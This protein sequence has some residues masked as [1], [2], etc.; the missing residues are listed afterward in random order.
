M[1][2]DVG[3]RHTREVGA[4]AVRP[5]QRDLVR[6]GAEDVVADVVGDDQ[7]QALAGEF[8]GRVLD[9]VLG[10][11]GEADADGLPLA[12]T[13]ARVAASRSGLGTRCRSSSCSPRLIL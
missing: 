7:V 8:V 5:Q 10:L 1:L 2:G 3:F 13:A 12:S 9:Q 6:L 11:G 4:A